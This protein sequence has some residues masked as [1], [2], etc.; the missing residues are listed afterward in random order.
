[1][2]PFF[3]VCQEGITHWRIIASSVAIIPRDEEEASD[4]GV[5]CKRDGGGRGAR[6]VEVYIY[7]RRKHLWLRSR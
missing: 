5:N 6:A 3:I 7:S 4:T 1:M 2:D